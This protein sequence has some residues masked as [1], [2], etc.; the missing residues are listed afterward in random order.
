MKYLRGIPKT[1]QHL[2]S[3]PLKPGM[4]WSCCSEHACQW[5]ENNPEAFTAV[6]CTEKNGL[7]GNQKKKLEG[8]RNEHKS[9]SNYVG[10]EFGEFLQSVQ[11]LTLR[12]F[13]RIGTCVVD[14]FRAE[15]WKGRT[16]APMVILTPASSSKISSLVVFQEMAGGMTQQP[17][18]NLTDGW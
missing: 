6:S 12:I 2:P 1:S 13:I 5:H 18:P 4:S 14:I 9:S 7:V 11:L 15:F 10:Q 8:L 17:D 16:S 3:V